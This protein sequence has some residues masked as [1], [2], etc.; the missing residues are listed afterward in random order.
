MAKAGEHAGPSCPR[1]GRRLRMKPGTKRTT[2]GESLRF[3]CRNCFGTH[4]DACEWH[5]AMVAMLNEMKANGGTLSED[6]FA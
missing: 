3:Q 4:P 1:C 6:D 2:P 5:P